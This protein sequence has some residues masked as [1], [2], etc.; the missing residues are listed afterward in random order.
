MAEM[1]KVY[2][3]TPILVLCAVNTAGLS[4]CLPRRGLRLTTYSQL[5][6]SLASLFASE[7]LSQICM[8]LVG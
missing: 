8:K 3:K 6:P 5:A 4:L 2:C 1:K 7:F